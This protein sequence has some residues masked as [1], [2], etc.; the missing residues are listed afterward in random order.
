MQ[1]LF[2]KQDSATTT[3]FISPCPS[4]PGG[5]GPST[6]RVRYWIVDRFSFAHHR[7]VGCGNLGAPGSTFTTTIL[8]AEPH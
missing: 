7:G 5:V 2:A 6:E 1:V 3:T 8:D 4:P